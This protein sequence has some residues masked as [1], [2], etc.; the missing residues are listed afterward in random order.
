MPD[1]YGTGQGLL[2]GGWFTFDVTA[3]GGQR[4]YS[5]QG[6]VTSSGSAT[7]PIY[8]SEGGNFDAPPAVGVTTV[9]QATLAFS[10]CTHGTL[11]YAFTDGSGRNGSIAL[12]RLGN[13]VACVPGGD[14]TPPGSYY[15][16]G[17][18]YE[19]ATAGQG[20]VF[21]VDPVGHTLFA[22]WYTYAT[23][24]AQIGGPASERWFTIQS[25]FTPGSGHVSNIPIYQTTGGVFDQPTSATTTP[26]GT[27]NITYHNCNSATLTYTFNAGTNSG[28][29]G[30]IDLARVTP[31]PSS[32]SL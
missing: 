14:S 11:T 20:F 7:M 1:F 24:G 3:A 26:V 29:S 2:F 30:S 32:C 31:A 12:S 13:N 23:N 27:A 5:V 9:G 25:S 19:P 6:T 28:H 22:A 10:D 4:W 18:W 21:D 8:R 16:S 17:A 15:L